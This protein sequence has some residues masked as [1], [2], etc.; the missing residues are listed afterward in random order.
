MLLRDQ[1]AHRRGVSPTQYDPLVQLLQ[2]R[3]TSEEQYRVACVKGSD[4]F[5]LDDFR[6]PVPPTRQAVYTGK[7]ATSSVSLTISIPLIPLLGI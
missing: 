6:A 4:S 3:T 7:Q 2:E 5:R 1:R